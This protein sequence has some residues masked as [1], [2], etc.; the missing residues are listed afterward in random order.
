MEPLEKVLSFSIRVCIEKTFH[1]HRWTGLI[2]SSFGPLPFFEKLKD[3]SSDMSLIFY[4][5]LILEIKLSVIK[6]LWCYLLVDLSKQTWRPNTFDSGFEVR[7]SQC[8]FWYW[9]A[10]VGQNSLC[11]RMPVQYHLKR[12]FIRFRP[13]LALIGNRNKSLC[14]RYLM[15]STV[16]TFFDEFQKF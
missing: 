9:L 3:L 2:Q 12:L 16:D 6:L 8:R 5:D 14:I 15:M 1:L 13:M 10:T 7:F 4:T 11:V